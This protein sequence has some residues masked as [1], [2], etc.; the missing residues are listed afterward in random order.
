MVSGIPYAGETPMQEVVVKATEA[1]KQIEV[2]RI[3]PH[4]PKLDGVL[5]DP[6][7]TL[8]RSDEAAGSLPSSIEIHSDEIELRMDL[9]RMRA[10]DQGAS[11]LGR[12]TP[13]PGME[14]RPIEELETADD[15]ALLELG[16]AA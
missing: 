7:Y 13:P 8:I 2:Y 10:L 12:G 16:E 15:G 3:N 11:E 4:P 9:R 6:S 1:R 5:D 14:V